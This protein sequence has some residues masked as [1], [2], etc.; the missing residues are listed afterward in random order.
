MIE[1][2]SKENLPLVSIIMPAYNAE[3]YI[4][5]AISSVIDQTYSNWELLIVNDGSIDKTESIVLS[6]QD[7]RIRYFS[8][9]NLGV[10]AARNTALRN[11]KGTFFCMLDSDDLLPQNSIKLRIDKMNSSPEVEFLD[12]TVIVKNTTLDKT[13]KSFRFNHYGNPTKSL[14]RLD[15]NCFFGPSWMIRIVKDKHYCFDETITHGEELMLY[16]SVSNEGIYAS[17]DDPILIYRKSKNSAMSNLRGLES[18]YKKI[19]SEVMK[20]SYVSAEDKAY[21][22]ARINRIM[23]LSYLSKYD[24]YNAIR[25][26]FRFFGK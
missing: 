8:Q 6:F 4:A 21:M 10:S 13:L 17:I 3:N 11:M 26:L 7:E 15:G 9:I 1:E 5:E 2:I 12:G 24:V 22:K 19:L 18:G 14:V 16:L 20:M 23:F 25:I